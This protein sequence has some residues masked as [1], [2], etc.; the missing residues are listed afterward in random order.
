VLRWAAHGVKQKNGSVCVGHPG[1]GSGLNG[2]LS[3][4]ALLRECIATNI[5]IAGDQELTNLTFNESIVVTVPANTRSYLVLQKGSPTGQ[6]GTSAAASSK[7]AAVNTGIP[8]ME[9]LRELMQL[10]RELSDMYQT[11]GQTPAAQQPQQ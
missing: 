9:E 2:P 10:R 1:R 8:S 4:S 6:S 5:G 7:Q 3:E 11:S